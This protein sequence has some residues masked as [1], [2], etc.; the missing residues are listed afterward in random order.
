MYEDIIPVPQ[1]GVGYEKRLGNTW[2]YSELLKKI[3]STVTVAN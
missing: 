3:W 1:C 2:P